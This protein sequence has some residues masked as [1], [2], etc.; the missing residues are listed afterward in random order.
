MHD[1]RLDDHGIVVPCASCGQPNRIAF[2]RLGE[3][4]RCGSCQGAL[5]PPAVPVEIASEERF[6]RLIAACA[7][8]VLID[9]WAAW[10][11]PCRLVAPEVAKLANSRRGRLVVGKVDTEALPELARHHRVKSL[12][13]LALFS[14][15][16]EIDRV[17]GARP[18]AHL[19]AFIDAM[20]GP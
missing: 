8:P 4:A 12:P 14:R 11:G 6:D 9:F 7:L 15:G 10:C 2:E 17:L 19:E 20:L 13:T 16:M 1:T 18:R 3:T 5:V